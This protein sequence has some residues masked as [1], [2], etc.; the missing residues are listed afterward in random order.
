MQRLRRK[1]IFNMEVRM[2]TKEQILTKRRANRV[3]L[4]LA[5]TCERESRKWID[6]VKT[7]CT[8][9]IKMC[10]RLLEKETPTSKVCFINL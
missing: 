8:Q 1:V 7:T 9:G 3:K 6:Q 4:H 5:S 2:T 10:A